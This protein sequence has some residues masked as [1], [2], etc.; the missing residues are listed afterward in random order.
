V[1]EQVLAQGELAEEMIPDML[2]RIEERSNGAPGYDDIAVI[3]LRRM[4]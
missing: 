4:E 3:A 2:K 1:L